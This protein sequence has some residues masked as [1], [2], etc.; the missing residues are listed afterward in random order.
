MNQHGFNPFF[1]V[2]AKRITLAL[3][4]GWSIALVPRLEHPADTPTP[5]AITLVGTVICEYSDCGP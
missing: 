4:V 3:V 5:T 2:P 1:R